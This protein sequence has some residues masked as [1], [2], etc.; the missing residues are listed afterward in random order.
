MSRSDSPREICRSPERRTIGWPPSSKTPASNDSRVRVDGFSK[1]SATDRPS[2][3]LASSGCAFIAA[4]RSIRASSSSRASS[5]PSRKCRTGKRGIL[6][7]RCEVLTWNL[8][9]GRAVPPAGRDLFEDFATHIAGWQWDVAL[10][11]EVPPWWPRPLAERS[12]ASMRMCI[13][14]RTLVLPLQRFMADRRPD[15]MKSWG[16]GSNAILVRRGRIVA[17]REERLRRLPERRWM[18]ARRAR[19]RHVDRQPPRADPAAPAAG[20]GHRPG[21]GGAEPLGGRRAA[22]AARRRLQHRR[23]GA[24]GPR[25]DR[26]RRGR[27]PL[28]AR[29]HARVGRRSSTRGRS[30]TTRPLRFDV[31]AGEG[32]GRFSRRG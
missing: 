25:E 32:P 7:P 10:L 9:H 15:L 27:L 16:G 8:Y 4:A 12:R 31:R 14:G 23:P 20:G 24:R 11:Q 21:V 1:T 2:S 19:R 17:H 13:T 5:V 22:R 30:A 3:G 29:R 18:H 28:R 26:R 6:R